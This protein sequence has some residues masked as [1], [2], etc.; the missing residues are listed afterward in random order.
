M[1]EEK[2]TL[3]ALY[4]PAN[5]KTRFEFFSGFGFKELTITGSLGIISIFIGIFINFITN[6]FYNSILVVLITISTTIMAVRKNETNQSVIDTIK[7][8]I[9]FIKAQQHY[10][11][12]YFNNYERSEQR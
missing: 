2:E 9:R 7:L 10:K 6:D 12:E 1:K 5:I 8:Y 11:Y 4:I 3:N